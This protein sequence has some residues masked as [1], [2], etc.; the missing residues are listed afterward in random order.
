MSKLKWGTWNAY[1]DVCSGKFK[2]DQLKKRWDGFMVCLKDWEPRHPQD[3]LQSVP[4]TSNVLPWTRNTNVGSTVQEN[5]INLSS[6]KSLVSYN[7]N[8]CTYHFY[9]DGRAKQFLTDTG[10]T[11]NWYVPT[12]AGVGTGKFFR[13]TLLSQSSNTTT[14]YQNTGW[15]SLGSFKTLTLQDD[16]PPTGQTKTAVFLIEVSVNGVDTF[17][18]KQVTLQTING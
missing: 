15:L 12:T 4:E 17:A 8:L 3:F 5:G 2:S 11:E 14:Y 7:G 18:S 6:V 9:G 13:F 16:D 10:T 1:C